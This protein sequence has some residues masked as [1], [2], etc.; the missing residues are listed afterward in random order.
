MKNKDLRRKNFF[1][2]NDIYEKRSR[3]KLA[4]MIFYNEEIGFLC[5]NRFFGLK[6]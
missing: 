5:E 1:R 2:E 6:I 3:Y 4:V